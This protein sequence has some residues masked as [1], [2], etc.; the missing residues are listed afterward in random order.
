MQVQVIRQPEHQTG[1]PWHAKGGICKFVRVIIVGGFQIFVNMALNL[2]ADSKY[3]VLRCQEHLQRCLIRSS[4]CSSFQNHKTKA[5]VVPPVNLPVHDKIVHLG[6][7]QC[8]LII[9]GHQ[10]A[11]VGNMVALPP[12]FPNEGLDKLLICIVACPVLRVKP[13]GHDIR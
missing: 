3:C 7:F 2:L 10:H 5:E 9:R 12:L 13:S 8:R 4:V 6:I 1:K 11:H